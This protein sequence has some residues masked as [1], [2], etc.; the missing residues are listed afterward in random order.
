MGSYGK[1]N[2]NYKT[3]H[4]YE[5]FIN[6]K[7]VGDTHIIE[8]PLI[9]ISSNIKKFDKIGRNHSKLTPKDIIK[10]IDNIRKIIERRIS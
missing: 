9:A 4:Y 3:D 5:N 2:N 6:K 1:F 7:K 10:N 8:K